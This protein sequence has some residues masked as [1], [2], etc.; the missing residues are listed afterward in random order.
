MRIVLVCD[1]NRA[2]SPIAAALLTRELDQRG[3]SVGIGV[4]SAGLS[5]RGGQPAVPEA[6]EAAAGLGLDLRAHRSRPLTDHDLDADLI[7]TMTRSQLDAIGP[8]RPGLSARAFTLVELVALLALA[9]LRGN[10]R[11]ADEEAAGWGLDEP[12]PFPPPVPTVEDRLWGED[13][14]PGD[15]PPVEP[16]RAA[17]AGAHAIRLGIDVANGQRS[18]RRSALAPDE[19]PPAPDHDDVVDPMRAEEDEDPSGLGLARRMDAT[20]TELERLVARLAR[21]LVGPA[22]RRQRPGPEPEPDPAA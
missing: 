5:T 14:A 3:M 17:V 12:L 16:S 19:R 22:P 1:A 8:R 15:A 7:I 4:S 2:R 20:V 9:D 6:V 13:E 21:L 11:R 18:R 10:Q